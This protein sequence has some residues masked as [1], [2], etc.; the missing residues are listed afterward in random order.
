[1]A[2]FHHCVSVLRLDWVT[3]RLAETDD[4]P[5]LRVQCGVHS[6]PTTPLSDSSSQLRLSASGLRDLRS[7]NQE[8][9]P[10]GSQHSSTKRYTCELCEEEGVPE[11]EIYSLRC[12]HAICKE[13]WQ[14]NI[15]VRLADYQPS[16]IQCP[17]IDCKLSLLDSDVKAL[18]TRAQ[19]Q[20]YRA[21]FVEN[22]IRVKKNLIYCNNPA[23]DEIIKLRS[24]CTNDFQVRCRCGTVFCF[25]CCKNRLTESGEG[26][27]PATCDQFVR[28]LQ[29]TQDGVF[30][31]RKKPCCSLK[32]LDQ[33]GPGASRTAI[34]KRP[35][36]K[37]FEARLVYGRDH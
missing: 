21:L 12:G 36:G 13:C 6:E 23:C 14:Q 25:N 1:V 34:M 4:I 31:F 20:R 24:L 22:Y 10:I 19:Y 30:S 18:A 9:A 15:K 2:D 8:I 35:D 28:W 17:G 5:K 7:S 11:S 33:G 26:H 27:Y 3:S 16:S 37:L 32:E 29:K